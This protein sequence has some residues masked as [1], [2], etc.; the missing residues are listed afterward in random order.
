MAQLA[1]TFG[2][3]Y[4]FAPKDPK[5][6]DDHRCKGHIAQFLRPDLGYGRLALKTSG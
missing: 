5:Q 2:Y 1:T 4:K 6:S 3:T